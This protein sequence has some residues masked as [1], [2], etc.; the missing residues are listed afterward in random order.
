MI[1]GTAIAMLPSILLEEYILGIGNTKSGDRPKP[2]LYSDVIMVGKYRDWA[3]CQ[4]IIKDVITESMP[5]NFRKRGM[6]GP[7]RQ[8]SA[9][10]DQCLL[11]EVRLPVESLGP[12]FNTLNSS[13]PGIMNDIT[14]T[15]GY[16]WHNA[17]C[18]TT[19]PVREQAR[20]QERG[21]VHSPIS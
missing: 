16:Y 15:S 8:V 5:S 7:S 4:W 11:C 3:L 18:G 14:T 10:I 2:R 12:I 21:A 20:Q 13:I 19:R 1:T 17:S 6:A 9:V